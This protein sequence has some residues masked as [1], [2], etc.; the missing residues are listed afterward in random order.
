MNT[1]AVRSRRL[2]R[3]VNL[4]HWFS[5]VYQ[6]PGYTPAHFETYIRTADIATVR[7]MGFD[8]VRFPIA[9]EPI[10][11]RAADGRLPGDYLARIREHILDMLDHGLAVIVDIHP[12]DAFK[13]RLASSP[14]A[15][16]G[17]VDFWRQLAGAFADLDCERV[18]FE[19]LNE[20]CIHDGARWNAIQTELVGAVRQVAPAHTLLV[21]G[22]AWS[23]RS[24]L[25]ALR[26]P[27][28]AN[29]IANF[30]LYEP[31]AFTHQGAGWVG[32][33]ARQVRGLTY[34][35]NAGNLAAL[36]V[37]LDDD[38]RARLDDYAATG[39]DAAVYNEFLQPVAA[40]AREHN[41]PLICTEF[42]VYKK[43]SPR[44]SRLA[45]LRDVSAALTDAGIGW[46]MW[47]Y[48]GDFAAVVREHGIR[49]PDRELVEA[50]GLHPVHAST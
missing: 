44:A 18:F 8:H 32:P 45:W 39:W 11:A 6:E 2:R 37:G 23:L 25:L 22:D 31:H 12:E 14:D 43:F 41:L 17:F 47:D 19:L 27:E 24:E 48:A 7:D 33:W 34:P 30:H 5:Q 26:P 9:C 16:A 28:D 42:G 40:W 21:C 38:A 15:V 3:G 20:P 50:L 49:M 29:L 13:H 36:R 10:L 46:T 4:S 35:P 1:A